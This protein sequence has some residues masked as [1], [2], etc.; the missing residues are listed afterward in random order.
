MTLFDLTG[1]SAVVTGG[2]TGIGLAMARALASAGAQVSIWGRRQEKLDEAVKSAAAEGIS[3][4]A[5]SV[6]VADRQALADGFAAVAAE[7]GGLDIVVANA[8]V[9]SGHAKL[10]EVTDKQ[11]D[12][13]LEI[14]LHGVFWTI[15]EAAAVM[16]PQE[17]GGSI[18]TVSSLAALDATPRNYGYGA[19]KAGVVSLT[20]ASAVELARHQIRVNAVLPGW[21]ET[22][23]TDGLQQNE[24]FTANVMP[25][26]PER[27]WGRPQDFAGIAVYLASEAS[28]YQTGTQTVIDGGYSIF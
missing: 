15:R 7:Q 24:A 23:M 18:I 14:N 28:A 5:R 9:S 27:R 13:V 1:K 22:D 12:D 25:R 10:L 11:F 8:G 20:K 3:L 6:D 2:G 21:I 26:V 4:A 19:S 16:I 17:R